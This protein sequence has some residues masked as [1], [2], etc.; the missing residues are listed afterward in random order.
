MNMKISPWKDNDDAFRPMFT[1]SIVLS[2]IRENGTFK[3][4][5]EAAVFTDM[6]GDAMTDEAID[7]DREDINICCNK[8]DYA[9]V[10]KLLR[11]DTV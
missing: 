5:I 6:T 7:T 1:E 4:T 2:G 10:Q 9:F 11:G 3:Q 8:S